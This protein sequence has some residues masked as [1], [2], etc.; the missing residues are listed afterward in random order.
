MTGPIQIIDDRFIDYLSDESRTQGQAQ[1]ISFPETEARVQQVVKG[2]FLQKIPITVQGSRTGITGGAVPTRG[3]VLNLSRMNQVTGLDQDESGRF[4]VHVQPGISLADLNQ[5]LAEKKFNPDGW[6][7][8]SRRVH[9]NFKKSPQHFWPPDPSEKTASVGGMA[10]TNA[11]GICAHRYGSTRHHIKSIRVVNA[12]SKIHRIFRGQYCF[13]NG[14]CPLP[15]GGE[16]R[17]DPKTPGLDQFNDLIDLY[18]GSEGMLGVITNL[19][20][21]L[22]PLPAQI[23]GVVFFFETQSQAI[24]FIDVLAR[25]QAAG[26]DSEIV[27]IEF[28]D[29]TTLD[30]IQKFR[31]FNPRLAVIPEPGPG[32]LS[33]VCIEIRSHQ[34]KKVETIAQQLMETA[35]DLDCDLDRTWA[36]CHPNEMDRFCLFRHAAPEAINFLVD[37]ARQSDTRII[38]LGTDMQLKKTSAANLGAMYQQ[39]LQQHGLKAAIFGHAADGLLHVNILPADYSQSVRAKALMEKWAALIQSQGGTAVTE[40]G[41][42][43]VKPHLFRSMPLPQRIDALLKLKDKLDPSGLWN[44]GNMME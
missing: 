20:L 5:H 25:R 17:L 33:A 27:A 7:H 15:G 13:S 9:D 35:A 6:D 41:I 10:A 39:D 14:A 34:E 19:E 32:V 28:M 3:H 40:H 21:M 16:L 30:C 43:K 29:Q 24:G 1:T 12:R 11:R 26:Q 44:P 18:L 8:P 38:K 42:G 37:K 4:T 31:S 2:L 22:E 23:W 36:F